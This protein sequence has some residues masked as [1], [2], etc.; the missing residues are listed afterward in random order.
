V[1]IA[2]W[3]RGLGLERYVEAF[4]AND[5][6]AAILPALSSDDLKELGVTSLGHRKKLLEVIA[7]LRER[8]GE[9][10][11]PPAEAGTAAASREAERR[12]LTVMF[13]DLVDSTRLA[14]RLDPED[15]RTVITG[16]QNACSDVIGRYEGHVAKFMGDGVLAYFGYPRAHEDDA[17]RAVRAGLELA[18]VARQLP[19]DAGDAL[20]VRVGIATGQVVVGDL[21]GVGAAQE[22]A[23]V[24][25]TPNLA[26][27]LQGLAEPS[28]VVIAESTRRLVGGLFELADLGGRE[29]KGFDARI[30][31]WRVLGD[32]QAESRFAARSSTGLTPFVGRQHELGMLL[33]RFEQAKEGEGQVVLL[34]GEP[35][36]GKSRLAHGLIEH[37]AD[38]PHTRL[39]FYCS[40]YHVNSALHPVIEQIERAAGFLADD[41][42]ESKLDKLETLLE[43]GTDDPSAVAPLFAALL[44]IPADARYPPLNLPPQHQRDLTIAAM[45][46]QMSGLAAHRPVLMVLEDAHWID[47]TTTE[48]FERV[49]ERGQTLPV[50]LLITFRPEFAPPWTSYPHM[51][52]LTLNRLARRH[53]TEM[54]A[55][56]A[57]GKPLPEAVL[58][59]IWRKRRACLSSSRS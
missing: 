11:V 31:A 44:S 35:G 40:P 36:I 51:T 10:A 6:D 34:S 41:S 15:M 30:R 5:I 9:P 8:V 4:E 2:A 59:Q 26:A 42:A 21:I 32:S 18:R 7:G 22:E 12:Q 55:A 13:V 58:A 52:S 47:P 29:L 24:G 28:G 45:A 25:E 56:V 49:I 3:L 33:D 19:G 46:D 1:D 38:E 27:R 37:L 57:G 23:V 14:G 43:Q 50:L 54:I 53:S 39:R 17:E 20:A 48:L 16:Y